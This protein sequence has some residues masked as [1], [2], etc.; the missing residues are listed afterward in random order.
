LIGRKVAIARVRV[1]PFAL[2]ITV[3][4]FQV[5]EA[6]GASPFVG[7]R[8]LYVNA[9]LSSVYR[10]APVIKEVTLDGLR[11]SIAR[12]KGSADDLTDAADYNFSDILARLAARPAAPAPPAAP[13]PGTPRFSL[14]NIRISDAAIA[15]DDRP[16]GSRHQITHLNLGVPFVSTL[17]VYVDSFVE[18]GLSV[19]IDGTPFALAGHTKP[20]TESLETMVDLRLDALDLTRYVPFVPVRLPFWLQSGRLTVALDLS[21]VRPRADAPSLKVKG[22][23]ALEGL[24]VREKRGAEKVPLATL[25]TLDVRIGESDLTA[26]RF[27]VDSV[28]VSGVDL[29]VRRLRDGTLNLEHLAPTPPRSSAAV[30]PSRAAPAA[31]APATPAAQFDVGTFTLEKT[32]LH[33]ADET[34]TPAFRSDVRDIAVT[35]RGLSNRA[36]VSAQVQARLRADPGGT[37][38]E[39]GTLRLTPLAADVTVALDGVE[40]GRFAAYLRDLVAFDVVSGTV[41][42]GAHVRFQQDKAAPR[43]AVSDGSVQLAGLALRRRNAGDDFFRMTDLSVQGAALDLAQHTVTVEQIGTRDARLRFGRDGKGV[44]DLSTLV[45]ATATAATAGGA[46]PVAPAPAPTP[47]PAAAP[48]TVTVGRVDLERWSARF[49]D[50]AVTPAA[51]LAVNPITLHVTK[52][53]TAPGTRFGVELHLGINRTGRFDVTGT[54]GLDPQVANLRFNLRGLEILPFQPY[55]ADRVGVTVTSGAVSLNGQVGVTMAKAKGGVKPAPQLDLNGNVAVADLTVLDN[56]RQEPLVSWSAFRVDGLRVSNHPLAV[57]IDQVALDDLDAHVVMDANGQLNVAQALAAPGAPAK[58]A[59]PAHADAAPAQPAGG[60]S[61]NAVP[62]AVNVSGVVLKRGKVVFTDESVQPHY[63]AEIG[64][65]GGSVTGLSSVAG[66]TAAVDLSATVNR[67]GKLKIAGKTN[68]LAKDLFL[69][70]QLALNDVELPPASPYTGKFVGY[71]IGKGKL[72]LSLD[73]KVANR[74]L[75][76]KNNLVLDQFTFG[77]KVASPVATHAP[78]RLAVALLKDRRGVIDID[79]PISGSLD[80]PHFKVWPAVLKVLGN[81]VVKAA[82]A[83]FSV[84]AAA[85][86]G[87]DQLSRVDFAA[88]GAALDADAQRKLRSLGKAL[89]ERPGLSLEIEGGAD[90]NRDREGLRRFLVDRKLKAQKVAELVQQGAA[91]SS[92]DQVQIDAAERP[93]LVAA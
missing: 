36:G 6:D 34:V 71:T 33:F 67:S 40:P 8:K 87:G 66:S 53:S 19:E 84:I 82:T 56:R 3:E 78:V 65:L 13:E 91:V 77:D 76:A 89:E 58:P 1:N 79:L 80:D 28:R 23:V 47:E 70:V 43:L 72:G 15:F 5:F 75:E 24:D 38:T 93:R 22:Q 12:L 86:G 57:A 83:P 4:G 54:A 69:D 37:L 73:Y 46:K 32:A 81:L 90:P 62:P 44:V 29:R 26:Q 21:F 49:E 20:F 52:L 92:P 64:D 45:P 42:L 74:K 10:R 30:A 27:H 2:S 68:P 61:A 48:W 41:R 16:L 55:F 14:N 50:R 59:A 60:A 18:P 88:G 85:F 31:A 9:Q 7:F 17:P 25:D 11:V 39:H 35:V 63:G 51:V